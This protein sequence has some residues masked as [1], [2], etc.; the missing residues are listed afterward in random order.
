MG[1]LNTLAGPWFPEATMDRL[2]NVA[3]WWAGLAF[4]LVFFTLAVLWRHVDLRGVLRTG[5]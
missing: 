3:E 2:Q 5:A 1:V 4:S